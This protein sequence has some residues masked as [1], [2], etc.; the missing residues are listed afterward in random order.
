MNNNNNYQNNN[1]TNNYENNR[2]QGNYGIGRNNN[3]EE[4]RDQLLMV[5]EKENGKLQYKKMEKYS[6]NIW[7]A[8]TGAS[9]H[10]TNNDTGMYDIKIPKEDYITVA[11]NQELKVVKIGK[12]D[13]IAKQENGREVKFTLSNVKYIPELA[14]KLF[15]ITAAMDKGMKIGNNDRLIYLW[16]EKFRINFDILFEMKSGFSAGIK[17]IQKEKDQTQAI[18]K[19]GMKIKNIWRNCN[20]F[21]KK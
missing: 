18:L 6:E 9:C 2:D 4:N 12:I 19:S 3:N 21:N 5:S 17:L 7:I 1:R 10:M 15:S 16:K 14:V 11:N 13:M 8:D 20:F